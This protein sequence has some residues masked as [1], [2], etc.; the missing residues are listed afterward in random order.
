MLSSHLPRALCDKFVYDFLCSF[1][2]IV[3]CY[4]LRRMCSHC[5]RPLCDFLYGPSGA[6]R[7]KSV[8]LHG[9]CTEIVQFQASC[10]QSPQPPEAAQ[11]W[12]SDCGAIVPFLS[13][14][15]P[16]GLCNCPMPPQSTGYGLNPKRAE[17]APPRRF[18]R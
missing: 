5:L 2:G 8:R 18:A 4:G 10:R 13:M 9:D 14:R 11:R 16:R 7:S 17:S 15:P 6:S 1:L 12:C 3:G